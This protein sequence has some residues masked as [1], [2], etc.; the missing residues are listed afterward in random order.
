MSVYAQRERERERERLDQSVCSHKHSLSLSLSLSINTHLKKYIYIYIYLHHKGKSPQFGRVK[1]EG[2]G[3]VSY[4]S[5]SP[6][7]CSPL[8]L[9]TTKNHPILFFLLFSPILHPNS[10]LSTFYFVCVCV[11]VCV[12]NY[13]K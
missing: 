1:N 8:H 11:C 13:Y 9:K 3:A 7:T 5:K 10:L 6:Q 12:C 2:F 4:P